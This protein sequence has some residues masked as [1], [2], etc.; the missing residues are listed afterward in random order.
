MQTDALKQ[1]IFDQK[2]WDEKE[3]EKLKPNPA[4][5]IRWAPDDVLVHRPAGPTRTLDEGVLIFTKLH[6]S[7]VENVV[8]SWT[9]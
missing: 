8:F 5:R 3:L 9:R 2:T 1:G 7:G 6:L 4:F